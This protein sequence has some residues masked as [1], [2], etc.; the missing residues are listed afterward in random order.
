MLEQTGKWLIQRP[1]HLFGILVKNLKY[2]FLQNSVIWDCY[3]EIPNFRKVHHEFS[4]ENYL[5]YLT[6]SVMVMLLCNQNHS[7][8]QNVSSVY[9]LYELFGI[10]KRFTQLSHGSESWFNLKLFR[11]RIISQ[12]INL[13]WY[14]SWIWKF[15]VAKRLK[16]ILSNS[17]SKEMLILNTQLWIN[18]HFGKLWTSARVD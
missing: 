17:L 15:I 5:S 3:V 18:V 8:L 10:W 7:W 2:L 4:P 13:L 14:F 16:S 1:L 12:S 6:V 11:C 9:F